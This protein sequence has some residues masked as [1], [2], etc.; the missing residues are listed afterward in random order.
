MDW[1]P[2]IATGSDPT[3]LDYLTAA[4]A[5]L[6]PILAIVGIYIAVRAW[7]AANEN[8]V[9]AQDSLKVARDALEIS[10]VEH[11]VFLANYNARADL[12][13]TVTL[14]DSSDDNRTINATAAYLR[15]EIGLR[16]SG[17][18]TATNV[19]VNFVLP[20]LLRDPIWTNQVGAPLHEQQ[21][22]GG[23]LTTDEMLGI[24]TGELPSHYMT[25]MIDR[26]EGTERTHV[27]MYVTALFDLPDEVGVPAHLP[28]IARAWC[29]ELPDDVD[30][31][32]FAYNSTV[33]KGDPH[34][35]PG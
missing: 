28:V 11:E 34:G 27:V 6:G 13:L 32:E 35:P 20:I 22:T 30:R 18:R 25:K 15:W 3:T 8:L 16:N 31:E 23:P 17:D 29:A 7:Q 1:R 14:M 5:I 24:P 9:V 10:K 19:G 4:S 33:T 26:V 21:L 12:H 2:I